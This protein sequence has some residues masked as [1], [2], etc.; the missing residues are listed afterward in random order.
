MVTYELS[1]GIATI[2]L[3]DGKRNALGLEAFAELNAALERARADGAAVLLT[4]R[5]GTFS[6]GF[7]LR[8]LGS[9]GAN[10][11]RLVQVG[12][13]TAARLFAFPAPVIVACTG[14]AVAMGLFL[15]LTGDH[16][17]GA[18]GAFKIGASEVAIGMVVPSFAVE[19]CRHRIPV[20]HFYRAVTLSEMFTP[21]AA[22]PAGILDGVVAPGELAG[23]ARAVARQAAGFN[24]S[25]FAQTKLRARGPAIEALRVG[26]EADARQ[27]FAL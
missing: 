14:H 13:E 8:E 15:T 19:L 25:V 23:A 20:S 26:L 9:G 5:A 16:R 17:L 2:T 24:R 12:F 6:A 11:A 7:D 21:E 3:D 22:V 10:A 27:A 4:G 1:D 18:A